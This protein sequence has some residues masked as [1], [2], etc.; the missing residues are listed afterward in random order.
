MSLRSRLALVFLV[1]AIIPLI[2]AAIITE[3]ILSENYEEDHE[4]TLTVSSDQV[5]A[6]LSRRREL[7]T[8]NLSAIA[9]RSHPAIGGFIYDTSKNENTFEGLP[10]TKLRESERTL[11]SGFDAFFLLGPD[12]SILMAS[13]NQG[14][15][16]TSFKG[17][18]NGGY[19]WLPAEKD[20]KL[21]RSL[22]DVESRK[23]TLLDGR[24]IKL[25]A[26]VK[27]DNQ[28]FSHISDKRNELTISI[29]ANLQSSGISLTNH[30]GNIIAV[31]AISVSDK[32]LVTLRTQLRTV[33]IA[34]AGI[35]LLLLIVLAFLASRGI[36]KDLNQLGLAAKAVGEGNLEYTAPNASTKEVRSVVSAFEQ[37][38]KDL[39]ESKNKLVTVEKIAAWRDVA[40]QLAHEIKNPL[41]PIKMSVES[42]QRSWKRQH[43]EFQEIFTESTSTIIQ[44]TDRLSRT[45][46]E[47]SKFAQMPKPHF[48]V[49]KISDL[50]QRLTK[51]YVEAKK[52]QFNQWHSDVEVSADKDQI[53]QVILNLLVNALDA[54]SNDDFVT[55]E[56]TSTDRR[57][58][59]SV[60]DRGEGIPDDLIDSIFTPYFT[61]KG[62]RGGTGL[63]LP[64]AQRIAIDHGGKIE[65]SSSPEGSRFSL[66]LPLL[67][68]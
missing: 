54:S 55:V 57:C 2:I 39:N 45:L 46:D 15:V 8:K 41:T 30:Q 26:G 40:R 19:A 32:G 10:L 49:F 29:D 27:I 21:Q 60:I 48:E 6:E 31:V 13:H 5:S 53:T 65:V 44:E 38:T 35:S 34:A 62:K 25:I 14:S 16:G 28:T 47:F 17:N 66:Q 18:L 22:F 33:T 58:V 11:T 4:R 43:P 9:T 1:G 3:R 36:I 68:R 50:I 56:V 52:V 12:D 7:L 61:T 24:R 37:M 42:L 63:G 59:V 64:I 20:G 67:N 51:P 23:V